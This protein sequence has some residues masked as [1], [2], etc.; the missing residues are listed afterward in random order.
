MAFEAYRRGCY[1]RVERTAGYALA[2]ERREGHAIVMA[3]KLKLNEIEQAK[4]E[5]EITNGLRDKSSQ[6]ISVF[7]YIYGLLS[8]V[9]WYYD[10]SE[11]LTSVSGGATLQGK[12]RIIPQN[13]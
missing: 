3:S 8:R 4:P 5:K 1:E 2:G 11:S 13:H 12:S 10:Y 6:A 9:G 7:T